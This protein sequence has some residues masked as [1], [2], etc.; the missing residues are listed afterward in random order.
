M[1][2]KFDN[3]RPIY[4]QL[5]EKIQYMIVSGEY[6]PG[7][8]LLSVREFAALAAVN[9]NTMQR[10]LTEL[11]RQGLVYTQRTIGRT[12]TDDTTLIKEVREKMAL[13]KTSE[14]I[15]GMKQLGYSKEEVLELLSNAD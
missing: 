2:W 9:P 10:A 12:I 4:T 14:F 5:L 11:E 8:K 7:Q 15:T 1:A 3:E 13:D 6:K